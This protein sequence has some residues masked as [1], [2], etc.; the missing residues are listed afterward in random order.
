M[1]HKG[2]WPLS[3]STLYVFAWLIKLDGEQD[4]RWISSRFLPLRVS[5][6]FT[7]TGLSV[8]FSLLFFSLCFFS[9]VAR[10]WASGFLNQTPTPPIMCQRSCDQAGFPMIKG[11]LLFFQV[12]GKVKTESRRR[13]HRVL[14]K[15]IF[16]LYS[17]SVFT[18]ISTTHHSPSYSNVLDRVWPFS[19]M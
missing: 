14:F 7:G 17:T 9:S 6:S 2:A 16:P 18:V 3:L 10:F 11:P 19:L 13:H 1:R 8:S 4:Y 15:R 5:E 12:L